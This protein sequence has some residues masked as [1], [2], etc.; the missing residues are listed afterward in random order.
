MFFKPR[1]CQA[2]GVLQPLYKCIAKK[3]S[4]TIQSKV[5]QSLR[6]LLLKPMFISINGWM[7][8]KHKQ[9]WTPVSAHERTWTPMTTNEF[10]CIPL[11]SHWFSKTLQFAIYIFSLCFFFNGCFIILGVWSCVVLSQSILF[12][13]L[14]NHDS[15]VFILCWFGT[16]KNSPLPLLQHMFIYRYKHIDLD[17]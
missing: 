8:Q 10:K 9:T 12:T 6:D 1:V 7:E 15:F 17:Q 5:E 16:Q 11:I 4:K 14:E 3:K 2:L 13:K